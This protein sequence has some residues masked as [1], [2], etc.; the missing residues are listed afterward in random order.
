MYI[1]YHIFFKKSNKDFLNLAA[2]LRLEL[3]PTLLESG[4]LPL[5]QGAIWG[6]HPQSLYKYY[7][8]FFYKNQILYF[9]RVVFNYKFSKVI[10]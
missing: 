7:I 4:M 10:S 8:I 9:L 3:R 6:F 1:L 2:P 5:H